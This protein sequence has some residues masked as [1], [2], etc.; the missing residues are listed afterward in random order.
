ME[1][2]LEMAVSRA[3]D[4][5]SYIVTMIRLAIYGESLECSR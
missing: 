2:F 3:N 4:V 1:R 5:C